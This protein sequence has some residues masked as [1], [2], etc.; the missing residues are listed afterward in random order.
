[1]FHGH[2]GEK[3]EADVDKRRYFR[4]VNDYVTDNYLDGTDLPLILVTLKE[5]QGTF[6]KVSDNP[7]LMHTIDMQYTAKNKKKIHETVN[8]FLKEKHHENIESLLD[9]FYTARANGKGTDLLSEIVMAS[10]QGKIDTL[11]I[12]N[13]KQL[14]GVYDR[15]NGEVTYG[16]DTTYH[17]EIF[18]DLAKDTLEKKGDVF[19][20]DPANMPG[21]S[22]ICAIHRY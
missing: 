21:E 17:A 1:M 13:G 5:H 19:I 8:R 6:N 4:F 20:V 14:P 3:D 7:H 16:E 15:E 2:G 10:I 22:G 11:F 12:E 9:D 18:D